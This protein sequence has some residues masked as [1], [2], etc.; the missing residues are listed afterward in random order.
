MVEA[1]LL[2]LVDLAEGDVD[3]LLLPAELD[4]AGG[5]ALHA[6]RLERRRDAVDA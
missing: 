5:A 6:G 3:H 1:P 2:Q 4:G